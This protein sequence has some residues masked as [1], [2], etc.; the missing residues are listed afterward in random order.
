[1]NADDV[2]STSELV[3]RALEEARLA[4]NDALAAIDNAEADITAAEGDLVLVS[5]WCHGSI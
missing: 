5:S 3:L 2:L 1:M 4:Q